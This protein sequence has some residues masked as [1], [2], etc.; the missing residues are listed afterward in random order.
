M[1]GVRSSSARLPTAGWR[2]CRAGVRRLLTVQLLVQRLE[3]LSGALVVPPAPS[4]SVVP[5]APAPEG[6]A[7]QEE[8]EEDEEEREEEP[9]AAEEERVVVDGRSDRGTRGRKPLG[10]SQLI[11]ADAHDR[12]DHERQED[13]EASHWCLLFDDVVE[14]KRRSPS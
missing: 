3:P 9:E 5:S 4:A 1:S 12:C 13:A 8:D 11:R 6:R 14:R 7:E 2:R 10:P